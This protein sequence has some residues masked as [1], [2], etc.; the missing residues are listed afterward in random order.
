MAEYLIF[1]LKLDNNI[2]CLSSSG[3][4]KKNQIDLI[5]KI[6]KKE[7]WNKII[8][9]S[10]LDNY[11]PS[12]K[13]I[14]SFYKVNINFRNLEKVIFQTKARTLFF[15]DMNHPAYLY[16]SQH[17]NH[18]EIRF[19]EEGL[20]HYALP[21][22]NNKNSNWIKQHIKKMAFNLFEYI[23]IKN[24]GSSNLLYLQKNTNIYSYLKFNYRYN[25][26]PR[27]DKTIRNKD[28]L[29]D[30]YNFKRFVLNKNESLGYVK[31]GE[32]QSPCI[33]ILGSTISQIFNSDSIYSDIL[34]R[35]LCTYGDKIDIFIKF[36]PKE[37]PEYTSGV[38][39]ILEKTHPG[40]KLID[41]PQE[42]PFE[43]I[44]L[45]LKIDLLLSFGSSVSAYFQSFGEIKSMHIF[46]LL[47]IEYLKKSK[48]SAQLL[49]LNDIHKNAFS[50]LQNC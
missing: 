8:V 16:I 5:R 24:S 14:N 25:L 37:N 9:L 15:G 19:F 6:N 41:C 11:L 32:N 17:F 33:I 31:M 13:R 50:K 21:F 30:K 42:Y 36:H 20:A 18:L 39:E 23:F 10:D 49:R 1:S 48:N 12:L 43:L 27:Y 3:L 29:I 40:L 35:I 4:N 7:F 34:D 47:G 26:L 2:M 22:F 45:T 38:F 28:I 44:G 46:D